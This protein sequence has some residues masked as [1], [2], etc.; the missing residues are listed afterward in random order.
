MQFIVN[1]LR[2]S[3][4]FTVCGPFPERFLN[5]CAQNGV[6]FWGLVW[7]DSQT[8]ELKVARRDARRVRAL[9]EKVQCEARAK[10]RKG[11]FPASVRPAHWPGHFSDGGM[12]FLP[13]YPHR[14]GLRQ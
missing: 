10:G 11:R 7:L 2:G 13:V 9:A 14:G 6:G 8:L 1:F 12:Y 5:L 4:C 3:V